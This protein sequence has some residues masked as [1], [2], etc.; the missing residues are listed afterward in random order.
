MRYDQS[1]HLALTWRSEKT[2][3]CRTWDQTSFT[4]GGGAPAAR[5]GACSRTIQPICPMLAKIP[6]PPK[7]NAVMLHRGIAYQRS[8]FTDEPHR[9][10]GGQKL[11]QHQIQVAPA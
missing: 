5:S 8:L 9:V 1:A 4:S 6:L 2:T 11:T 7:H 10:H 3:H